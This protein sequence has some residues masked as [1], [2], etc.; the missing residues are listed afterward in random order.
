MSIKLVEPDLKYPRKERH[1]FECE[2]CNLRRSFL[3]DHRPVRRL[4]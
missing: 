2:K 3:I 1:I 4:V